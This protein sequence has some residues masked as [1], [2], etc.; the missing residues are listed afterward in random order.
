M[1][2][3]DCIQQSDVWHKARAG[4]VT[5]SEMNKIHT[6]TGKESKQ[7]EVYME[8]LLMEW[9]KG[10]PVDSYTNKWMEQGKQFEQ[11]ALDT[12]AFEADA[13]V[14]PVGFV[15]SDERK[16]IGCSPDSLV[17]E[18]GLVEAKCPKASTQVHYYLRAGVVPTD[19][20]VQ[21]QGQMMVTTRKWCDFVSY[22]PGADT[23]TIRVLRDDR[24]IMGLRAAIEAFLKTMLVKRKQ[25]IK[26]GHS[27]R[28]EEN[29]NSN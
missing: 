10:G 11:D 21:I 28:G 23:L 1:I 20:V 24:F 22:F 4:V 18:E 16:L 5:A 12:Y 3:L 26:L 6:S 7:A 25:L 9:L 2:I 27:P 14:T 8:T 17:G 19:Y 13:K 29:G 15:Y